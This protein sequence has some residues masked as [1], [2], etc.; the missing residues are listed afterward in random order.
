MKKSKISL[1]VSSLFICMLFLVYSCARSNNESSTTGVDSKKMAEE[2]NDAKFTKG[3]EYNAQFLV[4]AATINLNEIQLG[5]LAATKGISADVKALGK[6]MSDDHTK[7]QAEV[8]A[9]AQ[10]KNITLPTSATD[11]TMKD[12]NALNDKDFKGFDNKYIDMMVS[13]HKD[14]ITKFEKAVSDAS[15]SDIREWASK[16]LPKL[17]EH[18]D[19]A[20][21]CQARLKASS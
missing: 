1:E 11:E 2:H 10:K 3:E 4:D 19:R 9:L 14:A 16:M 5:N 8:V 15:D 7:A 20:M 12:Y 13:G 18:L 17:R 21:N 6:M